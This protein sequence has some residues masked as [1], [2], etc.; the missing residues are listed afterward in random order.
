[1]SY[2]TISLKG[3]RKTRKCLRIDYH[4]ADFRA[5][6]SEHKSRVSTNT[7]RDSAEHINMCLLATP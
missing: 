2:D 4:R 7:S 5:K 6:T 1:M 3:L